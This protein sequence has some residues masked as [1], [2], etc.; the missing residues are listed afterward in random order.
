MSGL[1]VVLFVF[2]NDKITSNECSDNIKQTFVNKPYAVLKDGNVIYSNQAIATT[3][4]GVDY[5][6]MMYP[7]IENADK[8]IC[9]I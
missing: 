8:Q 9:I 3:L 4:G 7:T 2:E 6:G 1:G 5:I